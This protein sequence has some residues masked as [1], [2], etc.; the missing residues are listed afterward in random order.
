[1]DGLEHVTFATADG[2]E[3]APETLLATIAERG[4]AL[5]LTLPVPGAPLPPSGAAMMPAILA[6]ARRLHRAGGQI[7]GGSDAGIAPSKPHDV[8]RFAVGALIELGMTPA[9]ALRAWTSQAAVACGLGD[10]KG[11]IAP[12]YDADLLAVDG[13]PLHNPAALHHIR[14][15]YLRG[16][17]LETQ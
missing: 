16:N 7:I 11:R 8:A 17:P 13:D 4:T 10:R 14:A 2:I 6:N 5:G 9:D 15:V 12:G 3:P 1:M